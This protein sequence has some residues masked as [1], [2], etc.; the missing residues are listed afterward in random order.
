MNFTPCSGPLEWDLGTHGIRISFSYHGR[1]YGATY[2]PDVAVEQGW[3][4]EETL[5]SLMRKAGW[6]GKSSEWKKVENLGCI[7]YEGK[8]ASL[9]YQQYRE[10]RTWAD[11]LP[12]EQ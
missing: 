1:R 9:G 5:I 6:S 7:R 3:T 11:S 10:W 2:L 8:R 12:N 4:K